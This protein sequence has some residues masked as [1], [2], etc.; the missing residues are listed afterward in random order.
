MS[1]PILEPPVS[2]W[3]CPQCGFTDQT[4]IAGPHQRWHTCPKLRMMSAPMLPKGTP[5][6]FLIHEPEGY[7]GAEL[8]Q[9]D[10]E[11]GRPI[12]SIETIRDEGT[13]LLVFAPTATADA[14]D[15]R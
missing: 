3:Y 11:L 8:V 9:T 2:E 4:R 7:V 13:D 14:K 1:I 10:P 15:Y 5:G 12:M 6:T